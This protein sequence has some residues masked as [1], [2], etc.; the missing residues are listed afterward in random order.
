MIILLDIH[1]TFCY[2]MHWYNNFL[3]SHASNNKLT[4]R[5]TIDTINSLT[6]F[7][8]VLSNRKSF[9]NDYLTKLYT[10]SK[11]KNLVKRAQI[12]ARFGSE[13]QCS[14]STHHGFC[15]LPWHI[16]LLT[17]AHQFHPD[18]LKARCWARPWLKIYNIKLAR[19]PCKGPMTGGR[20]EKCD[21][22]SSLGLGR[23]RPV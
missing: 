14:R 2:L 4:H 12:T 17:L 23:Q 7:L 13:K 1:I 10:I 8:K 20:P 5:R 11:N 18:P 9:K 6:L 15:S 16:I 19:S 3:L 22:Q 21:A